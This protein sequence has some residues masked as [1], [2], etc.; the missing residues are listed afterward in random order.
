MAHAMQFA[1]VLAHIRLDVFLRDR[2]QNQPT[3]FRGL[4]RRDFN[5]GELVEIFPDMPNVVRLIRTARDPNGNQFGQLSHEARDPRRRK[6]DMIE[7]T[8]S[9]RRPDKQEGDSFARSTF[10]FR[11]VQ[12]SCRSRLSQIRRRLD[13]SSP[14]NNEQRCRSRRKSAVLPMPAEPTRST[15]LRSRWRQRSFSTSSF[16]PEKS[17]TL[18]HGKTRRLQRINA[19]RSTSSSVKSA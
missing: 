2:L 15:R 1:D 3:D 11:W 6:R 9:P 8:G 17:E 19:R 7:R 10:S 14:I 5:A 16:A 4:E 18:V 13:V 12:P